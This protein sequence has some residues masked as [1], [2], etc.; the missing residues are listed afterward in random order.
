M[1]IKN[2][3]VSGFRN[4]I[5]LDI[6]PC[7]NINVIYGDNAQGK[8]NIIESIWLFSGSKSFRGAKDNELINFEK[9]FAKLN[10]TFTDD[11]REQNSEIIISETKK[12]K[13]NNVP[14]KLLSDLSGKFY[15]V[16][17]SPVHLNLIKDGPKN[18][19]KFI[20]IAISQIKPNYYSYILQYE[21]ALNQ[22]NALL[23]DLYSNKNLKDL[24]DVWDLQLAKLGTIISIF[25]KDY[26]L[27]LE[28]ISKKIYN[29]LSKEKESFNIKYIS[30]IFDN[31]NEIDTYS[32]ENI[33][34]YYEK[35]KSSLETDIKKGFT[36]KGIHRDDLDIF[37]NDISAKIYGSQGQQRSCVLALK[38]SESNLLKMVTN[39]NPIILLDDVMS[40]LDI[41]RQDY[42]LN[43]VSDFQV[44]ITCC[45]ISNKL[46]LK[47]GKVFRI[48]NGNGF[49]INF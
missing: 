39:E 21:K 10:L 4:L 14:L 6:N 18:R 48:E 3:K 26:I 19:R 31:F 43:H 40:E 49:E 16:V 28:K 33:N 27:K 9:D 41:T 7:D 29:G 11:F 15:C 32:D 8:T 20:D 13:L 38:L 1:K 5:N 37:V 47:Q 30:T 24:I 34:I 25:R 12:V 22:R 44:F 2:I 17:F 42:I 36:S 23:K 45:D 35:L 46:R